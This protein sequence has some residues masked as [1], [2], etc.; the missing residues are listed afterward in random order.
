MIWNEFAC[1]DFVDSEF[2][3]HLGSGRIFDRLPLP[4]WQQAFLDRWSLV[5]A[6]VPAPPKKLKALLELRLRLRRLLEGASGRKDLGPTQLG[7]LNSLLAAS[8]YVY[9]ISNRQPM[10]PAPLRRDWDWVIAELVRSTVEIMTKFDSR[11][12]KACANPDC[13]WL[14]YDESLNRSRR[15]CQSN[16][17]GNLIK[18]REHRARRRISDPRRQSRRTGRTSPASSRLRRP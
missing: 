8:P 10:S 2:A 17:C 16:Y 3:D 9:K 5:G 18:V 4:R 6:P 14:F 13:S 15:W 7:Y 1:L 12:I 11:R